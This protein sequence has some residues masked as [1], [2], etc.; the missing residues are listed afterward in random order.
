MKAK[1]QLILLCVSF[2]ITIPLLANQFWVKS[3]EQLSSGGNIVVNQNG[4]LFFTATMKSNLGDYDIVLVKMDGDGNVVWAKTYQATANDFAF[5]L[6]TTDEGN[7]YLIGTTYSFG[8]GKSD[9]WILKVDS[10]GNLLWQ[11]SYGS[12]NKDMLFKAISTSDGGCLF[13]YLNMDISPYKT[14]IAKIDKDGNI[15]WQK[16]AQNQMYYF[17]LTLLEDSSG[18]YLVGLGGFD[19]TSLII[20]IDSNGNIW[21]E[22]DYTNVY[23][24]SDMKNEENGFLILGDNGKICA[25]FEIDSSGN[26][27]SKKCYKN[28]EGISSNSLLRTTDGGYLINC[29]IE[30]S[31][32]DTDGLLLKLDS[33]KN[34]LWE[35]R[36]G[37]DGTDSL[38]DVCETI[39]ESYVTTGILNCQ[40]DKESYWIMKINSSG[41]LGFPCL[42]EKDIDIS[43]SDLDIMVYDSQSI[44]F[45]DSNI[46]SQDTNAIVQPISVSFVSVC[47]QCPD[48]YI[49]PETLKDGKSYEPYSET[50][51]ASGGS[52]PYKFSISS[53]KLPS[54]IS[55]GESGVLYGT[56]SEGGDFNFTVTA[57]DYYY[58]SGNKNYTLHIEVVPPTISSVQKLSN[59]F[60]LKISGSNF[61]SDLKVYIGGDSNAWEYIKYKSSSEIVLRGGNAL[62]SKFP[63]GV[64]VEIKIVNGDGGSATYQYTR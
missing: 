1:L 38:F 22:K 53:G 27:V 46:L 8:Q 64:P 55:L 58:C 41:S 13:A 62:K 29:D 40:S 10:D 57:K 47:S 44:L 21:W 30:I 16:E 11:K 35:K 48:I 4:D 19:Y 32:Q 15:S 12:V 24:L 56:P 17:S 34:I 2:V 37:S 20:K 31:T 36:Y 61:H 50:L 39:D 14:V 28:S 25:L 49:T 63:K 18:G 45:V 60:R 23:H 9:I 3:S 59:P 33:Q 54:G 6:L 26:I 5:Y 42:I 52:A 7:F 51:S 43:S